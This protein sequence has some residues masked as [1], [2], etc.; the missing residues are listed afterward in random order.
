MVVGIIIGAGT[1][2][3]QVGRL[4][5]G[6]AQVGRLPLGVLTGRSGLC[7][8]VRRAQ[9]VGGEIGRGVKGFTS[10]HVQQI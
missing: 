7:P 1:G 5:L 6:V 2:V 3:A 8:R 10:A 9:K 4:P